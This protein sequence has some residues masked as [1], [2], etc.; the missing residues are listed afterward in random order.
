ML[1]IINFKLFAKYIL[2]LENIHAIYN[3]LHHSIHLKLCMFYRPNQK[4]TKHTQYQIIKHTCI[5]LFEKH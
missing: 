1:F 3:Q 4:S 5:D 2:Y